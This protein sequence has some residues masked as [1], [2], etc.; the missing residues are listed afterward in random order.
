MLFESLDRHSAREFLR[1]KRRERRRYRS[2]RIG[3]VRQRCRVCDEQHRCERHTAA[4]WWALRHVC[5]LGGC[6]RRDFGHRRSVQESSRVSTRFVARRASTAKTRPVAAIA[7]EESPFARVFSVESG[8]TNVGPHG[9]PKLV[10]IRSGTQGANIPRLSGRSRPVD[11][12]PQFRQI[13]ID[14]VIVPG[15]VAQLVRA[16]D[17]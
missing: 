15:P 4:K 7:A 5:G 16:A 13:N 6:L 3:F 12:S 14:F 10:S 9:R 11:S 2:L 1:V 17:S 8:S